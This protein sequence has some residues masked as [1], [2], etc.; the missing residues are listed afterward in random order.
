MASPTR[1]GGSS[2]VWFL[3]ILQ[4]WLAW[5]TYGHAIQ[6]ATKEFHGNHF[7][8]LIGVGLAYFFAAVVIPSVVL[9]VLTKL[10]KDEGGA[11][12]RKGVFRSLLGGLLASAGAVFLVLALADGPGASFTM[13]LVFCCVPVVSTFYQLKKDPPAA[14]SW[15]RQRK[16]RFFIG[17]ALLLLFI[18][19]VLRAKSSLVTPGGG[20]EVDHG[21]RHFLWTLG[22]IFSWG[23]YVPVMHQGTTAMQGK[24][25]LAKGMRTLIMVG[26]AYALVTVL[27]PLALMFV[28]GHVPETISAD[29]ATWSLIGGL[30][31]CLGAIGI[32]F[33]NNLAPGGPLTVAPLVFGGAPAVNTLA[34]VL[35]TLQKRNWQVPD[36]YAFVPL[37]IAVLLGMV[38]V[39]L[40]LRNKPLPQPKK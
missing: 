20:A 28:T 8:P 22:V 12:T 4:T 19:A 2:S 40:I 29:G 24:N 35:L 16:I 6:A 3:C 30:L 33:G 17:L 9:L 31:G 36:W 37:T 5:G 27:A 32:I 10:K 34:F 11:Y 18:V 15:P 39:T 25:G 21:Y 13:P 7:A 23:F 38:A 26:L 1:V 14:G